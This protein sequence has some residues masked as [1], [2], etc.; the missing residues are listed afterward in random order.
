MI[1]ILSPECIC[2]MDRGTHFLLFEGSFFK[3]S[4]TS[5]EVEWLRLPSSNARG[6]GLISGRHT[7]IQ[8]A[9]QPKINKQKI[10]IDHSC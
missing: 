8:C 6:V 9:P 2:I 10:I 3:G 1:L 5:L 4:G 7:K